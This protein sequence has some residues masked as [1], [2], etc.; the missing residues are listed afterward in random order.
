V[1]FG[2]HDTDGLT[3]AQRWNLVGMTLVA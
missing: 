2:W 3:E 1:V